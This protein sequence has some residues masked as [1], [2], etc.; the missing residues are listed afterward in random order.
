MLL[1]RGA[2]PLPCLDPVEWTFA[3]DLVT[4]PATATYDVPAIPAGT[5]FFHCD[6]HP[7]QMFG[8]FVSG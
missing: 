6:V 5:Y 2:L 3:G 4:G 7:T 8:T 1:G